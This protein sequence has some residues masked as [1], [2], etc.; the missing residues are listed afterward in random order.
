MN[1]CVTSYLYPNPDKPILGSYICEQLTELAKHN[2][3]HI[4]TRKERHWNCP[5]KEIV[6][7]VHVHRIDAENKLLFPILCFIKIVSLHRKYHFD[8]VHAHFTGYLTF[9]CSLASLLIKRPFFITTYGLTLDPKSISIFKR[10]MIRLSFFFAKKIISISRYTKKLSE[11]YALKEKHVLITP[12]I[13]LSKLK[14]TMSSK[15]FRKK[16]RL[17]KGPMLLSV[18]GVVWRKGHDVIISVLPDIVS[19][20]KDLKYIIIGKGGAEENLKKQVKRLGLE[21]NVIFWPTWVS[22]RELANFYNSSDLFVLMSRTEGA[23]VEGFG[24]VYVEA[25]ALGKPVIGGKGGGTPDA[26][27]DGKSGFLIDPSDVEEVKKKLILLI[28]DKKLRVKMGEYGKQYAIKNHLWKYK[29]KQLMQ[30]YSEFT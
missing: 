16:Y 13:T 12:G 21:K 17:G 15:N 8:V 29:V 18:G 26:V 10:I 3:V 30:V 22:D 14:V 7:E 2:N 23:A 24:I 27:D 4:I 5:A 20:H 19:S 6:D 25:N 11:H 9:F 1:I 28:R